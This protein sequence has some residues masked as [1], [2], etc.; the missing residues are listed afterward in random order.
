MMNMH[1]VSNI[2]IL[3]INTPLGTR[4]S[5]KKNDPLKCDYSI[6]NTAL[7]EI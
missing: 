6:C 4:I 1:E 2:C 5:F 7:Y 3:Y